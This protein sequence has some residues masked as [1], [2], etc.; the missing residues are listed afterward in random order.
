ML[1][2]ATTGLRRLCLSACVCLTVFVACPIASHCTAPNRIASHLSSSRTTQATGSRLDPQILT[3]V[4]L[5]SG[6]QTLRRRPY[7]L[8]LVGACMCIFLI[9]ALLVESKLHLS[10]Q[11]CLASKQAGIASQGTELGSGIRTL[12][13]CSIVPPVHGTDHTTD[14]RSQITTDHHRSVGHC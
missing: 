10:Q 9:P 13:H 5:L 2:V 4:F 7:P 3:V 11:P 8:Q 14:H 12:S 1:Q 6:P